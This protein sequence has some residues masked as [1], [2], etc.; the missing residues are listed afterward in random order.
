MF[1]KI[2]ELLQEEPKAS[3]TDERIIAL[4]RELNRYKHNRYQ[5]LDM[6]EYLV[7][8]EQLKR[9]DGRLPSRHELAAQMI[10]YTNDE[11]PTLYAENSFI[12][13]S[14]KV[15]MNEIYEEVRQ[16]RAKANALAGQQ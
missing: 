1:K 13:A 8:Q 3:L 5:A 7:E 4:E 2:R 10:M 6:A 15:R 9:G 14:I 16:Q 12:R 11:V